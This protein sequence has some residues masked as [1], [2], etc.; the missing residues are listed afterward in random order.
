MGKNKVKRSWKPVQWLS[1]DIGVQQAKPINP[2]EDL[3]GGQVR[4]VR[5]RRK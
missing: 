3:I 2:I 5:R 1:A 4:F